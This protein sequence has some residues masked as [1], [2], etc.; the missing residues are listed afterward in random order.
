M[1]K[2]FNSVTGQYEDDGQ[3]EIDLGLNNLF[4]S[5][6]IQPS[7]SEQMN[8]VVQ[9]YLTNKY[10]KPKQDVV[11]Q[12]T[13]QPEESQDAI[14][15]Q[16]KFINPLD[17]YSPEERAKLEQQ[18]KDSKKYLPAFQFLSGLGQAYGG[19]QVDSE[20]YDNL[21]KKIDADTTGKFDK[22]KAQAIS[23]M[24]QKVELNKLDPN[25]NESRQFRNLVSSTMP[26]IAKAYGEEFNNI[27]AAD[28]GSILDYGKMRETIDARKQQFALQQQMR[29][30]DKINK[31]A[32]EMKNDMDPDKGRA[33]NFGTISGKVQ[34]SEYLQGLIGSF[35]DGNLPPAQMEELALGLSNMLSKGGGTS[36]AQVEALVPHTIIGDASQFK[37]WLLNEPGGANQQK[38][39]EMMSHTIQRERDIANNQLNTIRKQRLPIYEK[40]KK[41]DPQLYNSILKPYGIDQSEDNSQSKQNS[42]MVKVSNGKETFM[43]PSS[44]LEHAQADG[45]KRID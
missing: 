28:A 41:Q 35:K 39:V 38:F 15:Q 45:Y 20:Y 44:D 26:N 12:Q 2:Y 8:P 23:D 33:G 13:E 32:K 31:L 34:N 40:L 37:N 3:P 16:S 21:S 1:A 29:N 18:A 42:N 43:I 24:K 25:S 5:N 9:E 27:A 6:N 22:Q 14:P 36:R 4:D 30:D 7:V 11:P 19:R 10:I 17:K